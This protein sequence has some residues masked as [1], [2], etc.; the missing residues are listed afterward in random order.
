MGYYIN[1]INTISIHAPTRGATGAYIQ[2]PVYIKISIHAPTRGATT[3][4]ILLLRRL[5]ISIHAP[6]RGATIVSTI[7]IICS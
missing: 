1:K 4:R 6:T 5:A 7:G 2:T 3:E